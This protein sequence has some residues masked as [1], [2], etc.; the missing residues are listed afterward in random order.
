MNLTSSQDPRELEG[1]WQPANEEAALS[2]IPTSRGRRILTV[3]SHFLFGQGAV[4]GLALITNLVLVRALSVESYAQFGLAFGF[5]N[6]FSALMDMGFSATIV[7]LVADR[8]EDR[9]LVG[10]YVRAA[11]DLRHKMFIV[12]APVAAA[13]FLAITHK[14]H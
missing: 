12:L 8:R 10:R 3:V 11:N 9:A 13:I 6:T 1:E 5:Q 14:H 2:N 4:Q 7:P